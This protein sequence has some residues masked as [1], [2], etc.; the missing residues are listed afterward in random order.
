MLNI[1]ED[2]ST[3]I[4][5]ITG[6]EV[7]DTVHNVADIYPE[8]K[9]LEIDDKKTEGVRLAKFNRKS[10]KVASVTNGVSGPMVIRDDGS[11]F[12]GKE[13]IELKLIP[14]TK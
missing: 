12:E 14:I 11:A 5:T 1:K 9:N 7:E 8:L 10:Y 6:F 3:G 2:K 13:L 4:I